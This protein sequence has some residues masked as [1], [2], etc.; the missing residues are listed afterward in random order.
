MTKMLDIAAF[1]AAATSNT[2]MAVG[3]TLRFATTVAPEVKVS[4]MS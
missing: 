3:A 1:R 2:A 4:H